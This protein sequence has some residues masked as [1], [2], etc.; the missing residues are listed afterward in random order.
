MAGRPATTGGSTSYSRVEVLKELQTLIDDRDVR[1]RLEKGP[2]SETKGREHWVLHLLLRSEELSQQHLDTLV[3][4]AYSNTL[5]RLQSVEDR[6]QRME[7][8]D[9]QANQE[10]EDP[11]RGHGDLARREGLA[12]GDSGGPVRQRK[13]L[14]QPHLEP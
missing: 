13:T 9:Q 14:R 3:G 2:L 12:R 10:V 1:D 7:T 4:T 6:L 8:S 11:A 5:A